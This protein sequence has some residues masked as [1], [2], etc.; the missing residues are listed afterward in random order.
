[1]ESSN[2]ESVNKNIFEFEKRIK[3]TMQN[4][5][6]MLKEY[7]NKK[8]EI[9][10]QNSYKE[11]EGS[12]YVQK[13]LNE[14]RIQKNQARMSSL[15]HAN[16]ENSKSLQATERFEKEN[17][18]NKAETSRNSFMKEN[19]F[20]E[21]QYNSP[22]FTTENNVKEK[23]IM[24]LNNVANIMKKEL[25]YVSFSENNQKNFEKKEEK[26]ENYI[27]FKQNLM[28]NFSEKPLN[29]AYKENVQPKILTNIYSGVTPQISQIKIEDLLKESNEKSV[30]KTTNSNE[31]EAL[32][33]EDR[34]TLRDFGRSVKINQMITE[35]Q[36]KENA[37][38]SE[39]PKISQQSKFIANNSIRVQH[40]PDIIKRL[41]DDHKISKVFK[42]GFMNI[43]SW[44]IGIV[45]SKIID[46]LNSCLLK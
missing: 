7:N 26:K 34:L 44:G 28:R 38:I 27:N 12:S 25:N 43:F 46:I 2:S 22:S 10:S 17:V 35:K 37:E 3:T 39:I 42:G 21:K 6:S 41:L 23:E 9:S 5:E 33:V 13:L 30:K 1:M 4:Y 19:Y 8:P 15:R 11:E 40:N 36:M 24:P 14:H 32:K 18:L 31:F 29:L 20:E 16:E 45:F